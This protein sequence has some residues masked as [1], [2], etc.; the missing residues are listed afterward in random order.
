MHSQPC[1]S[2]NRLIKDKNY[3]IYFGPYVS[4]HVPHKTKILLKMKMKYIPNEIW[5]HTF[6]KK[7]K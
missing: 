2:I 7:K 4:I 5:L 6:K 1:M 3:P